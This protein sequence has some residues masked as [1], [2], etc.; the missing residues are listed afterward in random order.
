MRKLEITLS[1]EEWEQLKLAV[2]VSQKKI[3]SDAE[4]SQKAQEL[5]IEDVKRFTDVQLKKLNTGTLR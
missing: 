3:A 4:T 1:D 2:T 5:M